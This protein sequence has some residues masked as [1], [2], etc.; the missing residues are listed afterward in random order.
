MKRTALLFTCAL[1]TAPAFAA[2]DLCTVNLQ[3]LDDSAATMATMTDP[4][5][6]QVA[7]LQAKAKMDQAAGKVEDCASNAEMALNLLQKAESG[8]GGASN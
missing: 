1:L 2:E 3:K 8:N 5:K 7:D 6:S 4:L